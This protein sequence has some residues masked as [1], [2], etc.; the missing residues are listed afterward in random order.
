MPLSASFASKKILSKFLKEKKTPQRQ[1]LQPRTDPLNKPQRS[2]TIP[3]CH[4]PSAMAALGR[5]TPVICHIGRTPRSTM[6]TRRCFRGGF[7]QFCQFS[8]TCQ[9]CSHLPK[10]DSPPG[11]EQSRKFPNNQVYA[12]KWWTSPSHKYMVF[13]EPYR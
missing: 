2:N 9:Q 7:F 4:R 11:F 6:P 13:L 12:G 8:N 1:P 10:R 3:C 5:A